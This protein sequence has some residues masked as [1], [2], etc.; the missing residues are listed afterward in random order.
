MICV[1]CWEENLDSFS[2]QSANQSEIVAIPV[3]KDV[4]IRK[5]LEKGKLSM[6]WQEDDESQQWFLRDFESEQDNDFWESSC[7]F[8]WLLVDDIGLVGGY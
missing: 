5:D 1:D 8:S 7:E 4:L 2:Q 3:N 6:L